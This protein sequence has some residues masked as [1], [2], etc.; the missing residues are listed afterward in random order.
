MSLA[1]VISSNLSVSVILCVPLQ[2]LAFVPRGSIYQE[3]IT[4]FPLSSP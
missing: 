2:P 4:A 1:P 3:V